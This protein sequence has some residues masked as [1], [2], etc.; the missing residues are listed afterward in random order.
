[1]CGDPNNIHTDYGPDIFR[2]RCICGTSGPWK[3]TRAEA[4]AAWNDLMS[5]PLPEGWVA[6]PRRATPDMLNRVAPFPEHLKAQHPDPEDPWHREME[7]ATAVDQMVISG[8]Y[9]DLIAA[10]PP[11]PQ[12]KETL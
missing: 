1:M 2:E 12:Q 7:I 3:K 11:C 6:V 10:A 8:K 5:P 9:A 4:L